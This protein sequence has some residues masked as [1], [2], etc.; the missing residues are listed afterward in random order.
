MATQGFIMQ[1]LLLSVITP[2]VTSSLVKV[3][4]ACAVVAS[5]MLIVVVVLIDKVADL[6][7]DL[8]EGEGASGNGEGTPASGDDAEVPC[9]VVASHGS[10]PPVHSG[11]VVPSVRTVSGSDDAATQIFVR[12]ELSGRNIVMRRN[13]FLIA[14]EAILRT[15]ISSFA[16]VVALSW[17]MAMNIST[18]TLATKTA[19]FAKKHSPNV[20]ELDTRG[21]EL[22]FATV[23]VCILLPVW[24]KH[25]VPLAFMP[26]EWHLAR[27]EEVLIVEAQ[28]PAL[29]PRFRLAFRQLCCCCCGRFSSSASKKD[30]SANSGDESSD[31]DDSAP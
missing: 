25:I 3:F 12:E 22:V 2:L 13:E 15:V 4:L 14:Q 7:R 21:L 26:V 28:T 1:R 11:R 8:S 23:V 9:A 18:A 20:D 31:R 17:E 5:M 27:I 29:V 30:Q 6:I 24:M 10:S 19:K 16:I